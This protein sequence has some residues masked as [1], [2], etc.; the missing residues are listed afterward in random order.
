MKKGRNQISRCPFCGNVANVKIGTNGIHFFYCSNALECGAIVS[1][2]G[3]PGRK[4]AEDPI[5][6]WNRRLSLVSG[7]PQQRQT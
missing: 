7:F 5:A 6:N 4:E 2:F 1:F 3:G